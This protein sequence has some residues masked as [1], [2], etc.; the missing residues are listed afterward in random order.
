MIARRAATSMRQPEAEQLDHADTAE[1]LRP[2]VT[3]VVPFAGTVAEGSAMIKRLRC[4][5]LAPGD[6]VVVV[7]NQPGRAIDDPDAAG[8]RVV[9]DAAERSSYYA[10][11]R[12]VEEAGC[13]W[14]LFIDSDCRP[15]SDLLDEYFAG[16]IPTRCGVVAGGVVSAPEQTRLAARYARSRGQI[17]EGVHVEA[18]LPS[19]PTAN[20][21]VR[22]AAWDDL[23][24]FCEGVRSGADLEFCW[25]AQDAGWEFDHRPEARVEHEHPG[26]LRR[27]LRK[28]RRYGAG[29]RWVNRRYPGMAPRQR[30]AR[31]LARCAVGAVV[32]TVGLQPRRALF[33]L[34]DAL[35]FLAMFRGHVFGDNRAPAARRDA[36]TS[37][38]VALEYPARGAIGAVRGAVEA[39]HRPLRQD[40][41]VL[42]STAIA[43]REDDPPPVRLRALLALLMRHPLRCRRS[44]NAP[45]GEPLAALAPAVRR[46]EQRGGE[47][48]SLA[49]A[50]DSTARLRSLLG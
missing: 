11:N 14:I 44:L 35:W 38:T 21:L 50:A 16:P 41:A 28:A 30:L 25:R 45:D 20:L 29:R 1:A 33:K 49:D 3:V 40:L 17:S 10:R 43:Y 47:L 4:L 24:G 39:A 23:G 13:E 34:I 18:S 6:E 42:R 19:G 26:E 7:D 27:L 22:R 48:H 2:P 46:I 5:R 36:G 31:P 8:I 9:A 12:G 15:A 37:T 32:W